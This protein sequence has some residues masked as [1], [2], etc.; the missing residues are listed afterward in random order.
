MLTERQK[1]NRLLFCQKHLNTD[2]KHWVFTDEKWFVVEG[3]ANPRLD[4][5]WG[6]E[7]TTVPPR[8][9]KK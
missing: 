2:V 9:E 3:N 7:N 8:E 6:D 4:G 5:I 1:K